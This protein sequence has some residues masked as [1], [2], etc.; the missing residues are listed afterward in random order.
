MFDKLIY[1][2]NHSIDK[3]TYLSPSP[4]FGFRRPQADVF[5]SYDRVKGYITG[6]E[7]WQLEKWWVFP[8]YA[9]VGVVF[10]VIAMA[11][12]KKRKMECAGDIAAFPVLRPVFKYITA[13]GGG[14]AFG[15]FVSEIFR[16][17]FA[18]TKLMIYLALLM[19]FGCVICYFAVEMFIKKSLRVAGKSWKGCV[20]SCVL[21][22]LFCV[23]TDFN[24]SGY[25]T[26]VPATDEIEGV[27]INRVS[28]FDNPMFESGENIARITEL[29]KGLIANKSL[30]DVNTNGEWMLCNIEYALKNGK[31]VKRT[32]NIQMN[33]E[34]WADETSD[35]RTLESILNTP[36]GVV[37]RN[38]KLFEDFDIDTVKIDGS[39]NCFW[40]DGTPENGSFRLNAQQ[41]EE[42]LTTCIIP[43]IS[44]GKLG[45][46]IIRYDQNAEDIYTAYIYVNNESFYN[47]RSI[48]DN[49]FYYS[50]DICADAERTVNWLLENTN[51][52]L[53]TQKE[54][55]ENVNMVNDY[56]VAR[57]AKY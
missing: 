12:F 52:K 36:E 28:A 8:M 34:I 9:A 39:W 14:L 3:L 1:G 13:I 42:L 19:V 31:T 43:D 44:E 23:A 20:I 24:L 37:S 7:S 49:Y 21:L 33:D 46:L 2:Y 26:Y 57:D 38:K 16:T 10:A 22:L 53:Q 47:G 29:H 18:G 41:I 50:F 48:D 54:Y 15:V 27:L 17:D 32:Y 56:P 55:N 6:V 40:E 25:E 35:I 11:I 45:K 4:L 51:V 30:H 5:Y